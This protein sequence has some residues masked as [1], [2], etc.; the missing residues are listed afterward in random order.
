M[1]F[2][3]NRIVVPRP[4]DVIPDPRLPEEILR[5]IATFLHFQ[6]LPQFRLVSREWNV[7]GLP[8][9][10]KRGH[11]NLTHSTHGNERQDLLG[12]AKHYSSWKVSRS[13]YESSEILQDNQMLQN[14]KSLTIHQRILLS[15]GFHI[16]SWETIQSRGPNLQELT[17]IFQSL[18]NSKGKRKVLS[19]YE[20]AIQGLPNACFPKISNLRNLASVN[21][22]GICDE[23]TAYFAQN[24]LQACKNLRHLCLFPI[25]LPTESDIGAFGILEYLLCLTKNLQSF[26]FNVGKYCAEEN[27]EESVPFRFDRDQCEFTKFKAVK[28]PSVPF[29]FSENLQSLFWDLSFYFHDQFLPGVLNPS[30]SSSIVQLCL[31]GK[32]G[33]LGRVADV[34]APFPIKLSFPSFPRLRALKVGL[35][36]AHCLSVPELVDSAPNLYVLGMKGLRRVYTVPRNELRSSLWQGTHMES[37][38]HPKRHFQLRIFCTDVP[39]TNLTT[40]GDILT[41]FP[42]LVELRLG[43]VEGVA[44][45]QFLN[46]VQSN[47]PKLQRLNWSS[48]ETFTL[49]ELF[50]HLIRLPEQLSALN[51]Y[52]VGWEGCHFRDC[53]NVLWPDSI[54]DIKEVANILLSLPSRSDSAIVINLLLKSSSCDCITKYEIR[55]FNCMQCYFHQFI[56]RQD[57]PI[58]IP[59]KREIRGMREKYDWDHRFASFWIYK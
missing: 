53:E 40:I 1:E 24:L 49:E 44:L 36:T 31:T 2:E 13:V 50:C 46:F 32:V 57:L 33:K 15:S 5:H 41:K 51:N 55:G 16:W 11:Y 58:R 37:V 54:Q 7:A 48:S 56:R 47:T 22:K 18:S 3:V 59:S 25:L 52:S 17:V 45:D 34:D 6:S 4:D 26:A 42:N 20:K 21:F 23:T 38:S 9:L 30:V 29:Q 10:M 35:H 14:V 8:I 12:A 27:E 39:C 28:T 43:I 19:D